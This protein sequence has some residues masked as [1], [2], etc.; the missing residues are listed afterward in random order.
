[1]KKIGALLLVLVIILTIIAGCANGQTPAADK[2][3]NQG[4][5]DSN[6]NQSGSKNDGEQT[7]L[8]VSTWDYNL[9][10]YQKKLFAAFEE[11]YPDIKLNV[12]DS[13]A[14]EYDDKIQI[15]L[16]GGDKVDVV[17]TKGTPALS[18]LIQKSQ[19]MPL[20]DYIEASNLDESKYS[21]LIDS[22]K[23]D[24]KTYGIPY[25]KDNNLIFYNKDL[26]DAAGVEYPTDGMTMEEYREL[27]KKMTSGEG[28]DKIYGAHV[29]TW[30]S[31]VYMFARRTG[32][33]DILNGDVSV[34]KPYYETI[35]AMQNEDKS[36]MDY[37]SLKAGNVH[38]SGVFY[39][40]QVAMM[41]M[42]TWFISNLVEKRASGEIDFEWG[43]ASIPDIDGTG[44]TIGVGGVTPIS[45]NAKAEHPDEAWKFIEFITG[46]EGAIILAQSGILPGYTDDRVVEEFT[47]FE[48][49]PENLKDYLAL[50]TIT[51]EQEMH[52]KGREIYKI[53]D[54]QHDLIMVNAVSVDEGLEELQ[55]RI[56]EVLGR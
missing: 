38:Y 50:D 24:G 32:A 39:N 42:G 34:L 26:F 14:A 5:T 55:K 20:D 17:F 48:G 29:H 37:A 21:G 28:A 36:I 53:L 31:N 47:K 22:L 40:E 45:I 3:S 8:I 12:I 54:E 56:D 2:S 43:V 6:T 7:E 16:S 18:A 13:P 51:I 11:K 30:A 15:M 44:N 9:L 46:E 49:A 4:G 25:R 1:M 27:A 41:Q 10:E 23:I 33:F 35:L 52:S 19:V